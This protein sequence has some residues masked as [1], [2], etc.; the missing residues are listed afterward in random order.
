MNFTLFCKSF[1]FSDKDLDLIQFPWEDPIF[2]VIPNDASRN[3]FPCGVFPDENI[4]PSIFM[5]NN[6]FNMLDPSLPNLNSVASETSFEVLSPTS[7]C[8]T[9]SYTSDFL[10]SPRYV[11]NNEPVLSS[12]I[13][14]AT[15]KTEINTLASEYKSLCN[16]N[17]VQYKQRYNSTVEKL[18]NVDNTFNASYEKY[19][20]ERLTQRRNI[21]VSD[22]EFINI[23]SHLNGILELALLLHSISFD[24]DTTK[25]V[26]NL[27]YKLLQRSFLVTQQSTQILQDSKT[28]DA[29]VA[30]FCHPTIHINNVNP[31]IASLYSGNYLHE[32][33]NR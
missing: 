23:K 28:I 17:L 19:T 12:L 14:L 5:E 20:N 2:N 27:I 15:I 7:S 9:G 25:S 13:D 26:W 29:H 4:E 33:I 24:E 32:D 10:Q 8:V 3:H 22:H 30:L 11:P 31:V 6:D 1:F 21:C 18:V 16:T